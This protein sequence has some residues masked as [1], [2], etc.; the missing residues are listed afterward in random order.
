MVML[1]CAFLYNGYAVLSC[2]VCF[3]C[4]VLISAVQYSAKA[5]WFVYLFQFFCY[6]DEVKWL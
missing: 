6:A 5:V 4:A 1:Y 3:S 2:K